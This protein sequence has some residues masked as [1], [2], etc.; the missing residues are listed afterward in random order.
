MDFEGAAQHVLNKNEELYRRLANNSTTNMLQ[1]PDF[2]PDSIS[3]RDP[4]TGEECWVGVRI[5]KG[6]ILLAIS[7]RT[8]GDVEVPITDDNDVNRIINALSRALAMKQREQSNADQ[9]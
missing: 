2:G 3:F 5:A 4:D 9:K 6:R 1:P 7:R 8:D